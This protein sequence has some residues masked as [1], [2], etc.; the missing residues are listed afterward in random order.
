MQ[1]TLLFVLMSLA[2]AGLVCALPQIAGPA[3]REGMATSGT[4]TLQ[5][6]GGGS[7]PGP[8]PGATSPA[9]AVQPATSQPEPG[10]PTKNRDAIKALRAQIASLADLAK[11]VG[12]HEQMLKSNSTAL[13]GKDGK[14]GMQKT[15]NDC[16]KNCDQASKK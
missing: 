1:R 8:A 13:V 2:L 9:A 3:A 15:V 4:Y 10:D 7:G 5:K 16:Q 6:G 11:L 12:D 14:G